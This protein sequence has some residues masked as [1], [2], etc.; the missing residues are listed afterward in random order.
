MPGEKK[1][2]HKYFMKVKGKCQNAFLGILKTDF[3]HL[4]IEGFPEKLNK[5][6]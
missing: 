6:L 4:I 1:I 3:T 5:Q 2:D